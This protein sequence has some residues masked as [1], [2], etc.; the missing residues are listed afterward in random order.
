M[1]Y[2]KKQSQQ[3]ETQRETPIVGQDETE[4]SIGHLFYILQPPA[5]PTES[6]LVYNILDK[7]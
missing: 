5:L 3:N 7:I 2:K 6:M 1:S 4:R